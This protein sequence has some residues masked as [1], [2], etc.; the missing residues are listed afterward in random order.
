MKQKKAEHLF[1]QIR[2]NEKSFKEICEECGFS[3]TS[4][5]NDFCKREWGIPPGK[6][7]ENAIQN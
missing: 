2:Y 7:R 6:I 3:S 5:M 1:N 4:Q